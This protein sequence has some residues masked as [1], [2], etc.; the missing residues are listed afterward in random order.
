MSGAPRRDAPPAYPGHPAQWDDVT[1]LDFLQTAGGTVPADPHPR[2]Q[3]RQNSA[4]RKRRHTGSEP[5]RRS[6]PYPGR[7]STNLEPSSRSIGQ[8]GNSRG[9]PI[10]LTSSPARSS[11]ETAIDL[12]TTPSRPHRTSFARMAPSGPMNSGG[13][14]SLSGRR[15]SDIVLPR[16]QSDQ[17]VNKCPVCSTEFSFW[18][19]KHHCRKCGRVVCASCSPHR[20]TIPKQYIV[21]PPSPATLYEDDTSSASSPSDRGHLGG[22]EI[23]RVCNPCVPDPWMPNTT[24][25]QAPVAPVPPPPPRTTSCQRSPGRDSRLYPGNDP[26]LRRDSDQGARERPERYRNVLPPI[27][28]RAQTYQSAPSIATRDPRLQAQGGMRVTSRGAGNQ[29]SAFPRLSSSHYE[30]GYFSASAANAAP[31]IP[32][33]ASRPPPSAHSRSQPDA[34]QL[35]APVRPRREVREEDEC[36]VCG[37]EM[38]PGEAVREAH[39]NDCISSRFSSTPTQPRLVPTATNPQVPVPAALAGSHAS[40]NAPI[41]E[42]SR[43]RATSYRPRGMA[44]YKATEKDCQDEAGD[45]QECVICFEEFEPGDEMGRM[46]CLCKFHRVCIRQWWDTKGQ[47]SCP[48]HQ[49]HD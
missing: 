17:E 25:A 47:G 14:G 10:D 42:G 29:E 15:E 1:W 40:S 2:N 6:Y 37:I 23:V 30:R 46:E 49:L 45:S 13:N 3:D 41:A 32:S 5:E 11:R 21:Q 9:T 24:S 38:P 7:P 35:G 39:I 16:W 34:S 48:T 12:D 4:E 27:R 26:R 20:I 33:Q 22:G 31:P 43:P 44:L 19:R 18:Y 8:Q 28:S 36:P